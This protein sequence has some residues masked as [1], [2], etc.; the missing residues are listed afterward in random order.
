M[1]DQQQTGIGVILDLE[2][3]FLSREFGRRPVRAVS[4]APAAVASEPAQLEQVFLSEVFGH[5]EVLAAATPV[6]TLAAPALSGRPA[7]VL[8]QGGGEGRTGHESARARTI[9][10]VSGVAAAALAVAGLASSTGHGPSRPGVTAQAQGVPSGNGVHAP[11]G[12]SQP[13]PA[14]TGVLPSPSSVGTSGGGGTVARFT[15]FSTPSGA[16]QAVG[17]NGAATPPA[18]LAPPGSAPAPG[19]PPGSGS[20]GSGGSMLAPALTVVGNEV[21]SVGS[22]ISATSGGVG[23]ALPVPSVLQAVGTGAASAMNNSGGS[24]PPTILAGALKE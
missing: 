1:S 14:G 17:G 22:S 20:G 3:L 23:Q 2:E 12:A 15:S 19:S 18:A 13:G 4:S 7:L 9:A 8:L 21:T 5:P 16:A 6:V 24:T 11:D 10:A